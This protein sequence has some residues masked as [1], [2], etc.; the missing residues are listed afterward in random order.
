VSDLRETAARESQQERAAA[1]REA[2]EMRVSARR[3]AGE[4]LAAAEAEAR[5]LGRNV[6]TIWRERRR[7]IEDVKAVGEQ[8]VGIGEAEAKRFPRSELDA[9]FTGDL[10]ERTPS[11]T[12]P[13]TA[14]REAA[15]A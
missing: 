12:E 5:E 2:D 13:A 15:Q 11:V 7:L 14:A 10:H 1:K 9:I 4:L 6:E 3:E 8:L